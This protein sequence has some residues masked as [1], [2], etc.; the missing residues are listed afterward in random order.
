MGR[1]VVAELNRKLGDGISLE[2]E[3]LRS[4]DVQGRARSLAGLVT[5]GATLESAAAET[6]FRN[7]VAAPVRETENVE[8]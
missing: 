7:L 4:S 1:K 6:G 5:A 8:A 2:W 3:E